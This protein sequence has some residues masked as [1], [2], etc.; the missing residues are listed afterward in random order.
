MFSTLDEVYW[1]LAHSWPIVSLLFKGFIQSFRCLVS[2]NNHKLL[3]SHQ[4]LGFSTIKRWKK[5][6]ETLLAVDV[7]IF[8]LHLSHF[9]SPWLMPSYKLDPIL[10]KGCMMR[11]QRVCDSPFLPDAFAMAGPDVYFELSCPRYS[12]KLT[13]CS[14]LQPFRASQLFFHCFLDWP[15]VSSLR[16]APKAFLSLWSWGSSCPL[17]TAELTDSFWGAG[18]QNSF[19]MYDTLEWGYILRQSLT[20]NP[21][22]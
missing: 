15:D 3:S 16:I 8:C 17:L 10:S 13:L 14:I 9:P 18:K 22:M 12:R 20:H 5:C 1:P 2:D 21:E 4:T 7:M 19:L 6:E 11:R